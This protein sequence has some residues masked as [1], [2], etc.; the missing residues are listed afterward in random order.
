M[1]AHPFPFFRFSKPLLA[2][3]AGCL[4]L[5]G[6]SM[7]SRHETLEE[8]PES[9]ASVQDPS[10]MLGNPLLPNAGDPNASYASASSSAE[11]EKYDN[12]AEGELIWTDPDNPDADIPGLTAAFENRRQGNGWLANMG[13][14]TKL[15]RREGRPLIIWFHDSVISPKSKTLGAQLL[16]TPAFND[17][18]KDRVIRLKLD[19][20][21]AG[22]D[23]ARAKSRYSMQSINDLQHRYGMTHKPALA[24]VSPRGKIVTRI[25]GF[26]GYLAEVEQELK[27]GVA[28]AETSY[29]AYKESLRH[30]GFRDW[31]SRKG[32]ITVF[33]KLQRF[34]EKNNVVYLKDSGGRITRTRLEHFCADDVDFLDE[35]AR[36]TL[37]KDDPPPAP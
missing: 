7:F 4:L 1:N 3:G 28:E 18:C 33:A 14:A 6:C 16:E 2:A 5:A 30:R 35:Q 26:N 24:V 20:G 25:D 27:D 8:I 19:A 12:G 13:R 10:A 32:N 37:A 21:A 29:E 31:T 34:D 23:T 9:P 17:W 36:S 15:S 11:L 22:D